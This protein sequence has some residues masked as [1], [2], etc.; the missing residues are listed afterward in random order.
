MDDFDS[1]LMRESFKYDGDEPGTAWQKYR[2]KFLLADRASRIA[3][4]RIVDQWLENPRPRRDDAATWVKARD[5]R[6]LH[7][8]LLKIGK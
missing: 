5:L 8:D 3:E 1:D 4:L 6:M 7:A 2:A